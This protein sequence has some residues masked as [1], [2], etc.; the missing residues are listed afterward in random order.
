MCR[1]NIYDM[2]SYTDI[3]C[4]KVLPYSEAR[5]LCDKLVKDHLLLANISFTLIKYFV[6]GFKPRNLMIFRQFSWEKWSK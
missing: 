3:T 4:N 1:P 2:T 6:C 5:G